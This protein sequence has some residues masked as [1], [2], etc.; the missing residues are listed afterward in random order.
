MR[1][2]RKDPIPELVQQRILDA[3]VRAPSGGNGQGWRFLLVDDPKVKGQLGP[4]YRGCMEKLWG[5][6]YKDRVDAAKASPDKPESIEF[7]KMF[8]S[9][10]YLADHFEDYP[11]L[12]F[13]FCQFDTSGG[14]IFPAVWSAMLAARVEG[15][16]SALTSVFHFDYEPVKEILGVPDE[17][18]WHF[19]AC[20]TFGYPTGRWGVAPRRPVHEVSSRNSWDGELGF[21]IPEPLWSKA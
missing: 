21:E 2:T 20:V 10:S 7:D 12:L 17:G 6:I 13:A 16:G 11:L 1:R 15:V 8:R 4:I 9:A 14:S 3:A 5:S 18:D 19:N